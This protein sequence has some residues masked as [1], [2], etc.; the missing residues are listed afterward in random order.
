M[1]TFLPH[2]R[3]RAAG[4]PKELRR[5]L[6]HHPYANP[7]RYP[8]KSHLLLPAFPQRRSLPYDP[9][10]TTTTF[11]FI[12][13]CS[14]GGSIPTIEPATHSPILFLHTYILPFKT[15]F[16][17]VFLPLLSV[18][19]PSESPCFRSLTVVP[20][21]HLSVAIIDISSI[22]STTCT[23]TPPST[24]TRQSHHISCCASAA[25][26]HSHTLLA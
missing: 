3:A 26:I 22:M 23:S 11:T 19:S 13:F 2:P 6:Y 16:T 25:Y 24:P 21:I 15:A 12:I 10:P 5:S 8:Y 4:T 9:V 17:R 7:P 1:Y 18:S 20:T 14:F